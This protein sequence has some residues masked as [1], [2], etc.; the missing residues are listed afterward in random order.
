[1][2]PTLAVFIVLLLLL[3]TAGYS[4]TDTASIPVNL[5]IEPYT[6]IDI[7][8]D[9]IMTTV[10][11]WWFSSGMEMESVGSTSVQVG[12]NTNAT[13]VCPATL[14]MQLIDPPGPEIM[15]VRTAVSYMYPGHPQYY[16]QGGQVI[17]I[18]LEPGLHTAISLEASLSKVWNVGEDLAGTYQ[19]TLTVTVTEN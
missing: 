9:I 5:T 7:A 19:G 2:K 16:A 17:C 8:N 11:G 15:T 18:D 4:Q 12:T 6:E 3:T 10:E 13:L 1:M 14:D